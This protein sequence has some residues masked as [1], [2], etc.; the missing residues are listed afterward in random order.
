MV[1]SYGRHPTNIKVANDNLNAMRMVKN[2]V[3]HEGFA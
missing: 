2:V 3:Y 1:L